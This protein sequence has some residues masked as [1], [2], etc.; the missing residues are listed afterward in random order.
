MAQKEY[1]RNAIDE[2]AATSNIF[3]EAR[4][5]LESFYQEA[6]ERPLRLN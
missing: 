3:D 1:L 4:D 6:G 5:W 2:C